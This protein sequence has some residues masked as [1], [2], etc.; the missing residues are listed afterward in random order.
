MSGSGCQLCIFSFK[1]QQFPFAWK[2][3]KIKVT[4]S[5][6]LVYKLFQGII[7]Y[8]I[9]KNLWLA[10]IPLLGEIWLSAHCNLGKCDQ[11]YNLHIVSLPSIF[12]NWKHVC[13]RLV[14][15]SFVNW[16]SFWQSSLDCGYLKSWII[17]LLLL[18]SL[19]YPFLALQDKS[20]YFTSYD[21]NPPCSIILILVAA[22]EAFLVETKIPWL[23]YSSSPVYIDLSSLSKTNIFSNMNV[24]NWR[25]KT[26]VVY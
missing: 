16:I 18:N 11:Y 20:H 24:L 26:G 12:E 10:W 3:Y 7:M 17:Y 1:S 5:S 22:V 21:L 6:I 13:H 8:M 9:Q 23:E 14:T 19:S 15:M 2:I 4:K 25:F